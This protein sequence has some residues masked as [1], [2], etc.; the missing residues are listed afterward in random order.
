MKKAPGVISALAAAAL[1]LAGGCAKRTNESRAALFRGD[2]Q[3]T[4]VYRTKAP[5]RLTGLKWKFKTGAEVVSSP[6]IAAGTALFGSMDGIFY[7]V[8]TGAGEERWRFKTGGSSGFERS[9]GEDLVVGISIKEGVYKETLKSKTGAGIGSSAAVAG[10]LILFGSLDGHLYALDVN[11]GKEKWRFRTDGLVLSSPVV[12][13]G[14]AFF[15]SGDA[16]L[17]AVDVRT[18]QER[19]RF[20][21]GGPVLSS[22][23]VLP[24][25]VVFGSH[26][27]K[28]Y[29]ADLDTGHE[30]WR[31]ET[32]GG[33]ALRLDPGQL[34]PAVFGG[35]AYVGKTQRYTPLGGEFYA[36]GVGQGQ[37]RWQAAGLFLGGVAGSPAVDGALVYFGSADPE[38]VPGERLIRVDFRGGE[39]YALDAKTGRWR[40]GFP[41]PGFVHSSPSVADGVV[42]IGCDDGRMYALE[43][44]TGKPVWSFET[45]GRVASS[46]TVA[47]GVVYFG[48]TDGNLYALH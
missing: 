24:G 11:T 17:Y 40:W 42:Y 6:V 18:G 33:A 7:A 20:E 1:A 8:E 16:N 2:L 32:G 9:R 36:V 48:S 30:K 27:G 3:R 45:G 22:P 28:L 5:K 21:T 19:W 44:A 47:E 37:L 12:A 15:G 38:P 35:V 25:A 29:A 4:G 41:T 46:P 26:E 31:F 10:D 34:S 39:V 14:T 43:A 13:R 23:A